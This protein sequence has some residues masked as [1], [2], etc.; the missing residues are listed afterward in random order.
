MMMWKFELLI[1][2]NDE[3][4]ILWFQIIVISFIQGSS[5]VKMVGKKLFYYLLFIAWTTQSI[6]FYNIKKI[7]KINCLFK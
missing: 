7:K 1:L 3:L 6:Y 5:I 4:N 2:M